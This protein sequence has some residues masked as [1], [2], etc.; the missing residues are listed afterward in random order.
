MDTFYKP[1]V[2]GLRVSLWGIILPAKLFI[3]KWFWPSKYL[4]LCAAYGCNA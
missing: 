3:I 2:S 4:L 1:F